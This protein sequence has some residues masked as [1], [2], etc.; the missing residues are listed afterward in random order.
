M[1]R[2]AALSTVL[3]GFFAALPP[4][5]AA[6]TNAAPSAQTRTVLVPF[7]HERDSEGVFELPYYLARP[8]DESKSTVFL[9]GDGQQ[10]YVRPD[11]LPG[12]QTRDDGD[13][14][15]LVGI[16]GRASVEDVQRRVGHGADWINAYRLYRWEQWI[17]DIDAVRRALVGPEG[18][19]AL[20]GSSGGGTLV[21]QYLAR[22]G[23]HVSRAYTEASVNGYLDAEIGID[24]DRFWQEISEA[25]RRSIRSI[26]ERAAYPRQLVAAL[27]QRQN[28]FVP[29]N[30]LAGARS[31]LVRALFLGDDVMVKKLRRT[32]QVDAIADLEQSAL[33][34]A[35]R[36]RLYEF[37]APLAARF[38]RY[39]PELHPDHE[40]SANTARP[41]LD[42]QRAG[43]IASPRFDFAALHDI[44]AEVLIVAGHDDHTADYR[45]QFALASQ[46]RNHRFILLDDDHTFKRLKDSGLRPK[47]IRAAR[48]GF[49]APAFK[50]VVAALQPLIW[51]E[52]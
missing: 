44:G 10:F 8:F 52:P 37:F 38:D 45:S 36:V 35:V 20:R 5:I 16:A 51:R 29:P 32:Y 30:K 26:L 11:L 42:L 34:P 28:F 3:G 25:D 23:R 1:T 7:D 43:K 19:V 47:L 41:L 33:G 14:V 27:F 2:A 49:D 31:E 17:A 48:F 50:Q 24:S 15:N 4:P 13:D 18:R 6:A 9:I 39:G 21:H 12:Y 40:A 22:Y 46:Y